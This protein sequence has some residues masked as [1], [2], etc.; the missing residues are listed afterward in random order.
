MVIQS[1]MSAKLVVQTWQETSDIFIKYNI[2]IVDQ[3]INEV[4]EP[5]LLKELL[6]E[7]NTQVGSSS[8]TCVEGG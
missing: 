2:P 1:N 6:T 4:V 8:L 5:K 7:L 3:A